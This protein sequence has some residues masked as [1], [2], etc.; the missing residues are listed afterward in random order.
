MRQL[1]T[2]K[3]MPRFRLYQTPL[4]RLHFYSSGDKWQILLGKKRDLWNP[5]NSISNWGAGRDLMGGRDFMLPAVEAK[6]PN[7]RLSYSA[8]GGRMIAFLISQPSRRQLFPRRQKTR[9]MQKGSQW[10]RVARLLDRS[11]QW[12]AT[13]HLELFPCHAFELGAPEGS[14]KAARIRARRES[15]D[16]CV[17][18]EAPQSKDSK[19]QATAFLLGV[20]HLKKAAAARV[21]MP[22]PKGLEDCLPVGL[23]GSRITL[24]LERLS[25]SGGT[26][27]PYEVSFGH[28]D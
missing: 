23:D 2:E 13:S 9:N 21:L 22:H 14:W 6:A 19:C 4:Q 26:E 25:R 28:W 1:K 18:R 10:R 24:E 5:I 15:R 3:G 12:S 7:R 17:F 20:P 11:H 27:L 8:R 16:L